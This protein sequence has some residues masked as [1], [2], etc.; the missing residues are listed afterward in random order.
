MSVDDS[1][2]TVTGEGGRL[3]REAHLLDLGDL[4][5]VAEWVAQAA[6]SGVIGA[7]TYDVLKA[8]RRRFGSPATKRPAPLPPPSPHRETSGTTTPG[9]HHAGFFGFGTGS[10]DPWFFADFRFRLIDHS[11]P[12]PSLHYRSHSWTGKNRGRL[13][14]A[15]RPLRTTDSAISKGI[16]NAADSRGYCRDP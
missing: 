6:T 11:A 3:E 15:L 16:P 2:E 9:H 13:F 12:V 4:Q 8:V 14:L 5:A 10:F 7:V 1:Q